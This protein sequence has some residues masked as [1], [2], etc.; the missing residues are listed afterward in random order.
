MYFYLF[1]RAHGGRWRPF[2]FTDTERRAQET[3]EQELK[4]RNQTNY[5]W[6]TLTVEKT[7]PFSGQALLSVTAG[8]RV[9]V[10]F[11]LSSE[12]NNPFVL[13]PDEEKCPHQECPVSICLE[14]TKY[15]RFDADADD[16]VFLSDAR[17]TLTK[18]KNAY[19]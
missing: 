1:R 14:A 19:G 18:L 3:L 11:L 10:A 13:S 8:K 2:Y 4:T 5:R 6:K 7:G 9:V 12:A 15:L 16:H 17:R